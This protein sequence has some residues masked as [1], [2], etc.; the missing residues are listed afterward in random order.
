VGPVYIAPLTGMHYADA[1]AGTSMHR[2]AGYEE[3]GGTKNSLDAAST[4]ASKNPSK[5]KYAP[6]H[7]SGSPDSQA[8]P[9]WTTLRVIRSFAAS[10]QSHPKNRD[11]ALAVVAKPR[12]EDTRKRSGFSGSGDDRRVSES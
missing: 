4:Q 1:A 9:Q 8:V 7:H 12:M 5:P 2:R 6:S 3:L 11:V 10:A